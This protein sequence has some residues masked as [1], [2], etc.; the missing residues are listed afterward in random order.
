MS[1]GFGKQADTWKMNYDFGL[2]KQYSLACLSDQTNYAW[3]LEL[4]SAGR[5]YHNLNVTLR[6]SVPKNVSIGL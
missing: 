6:N 1:L 2:F 3:Y 4:R 5:R